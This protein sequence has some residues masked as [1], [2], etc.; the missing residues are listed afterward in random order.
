MKDSYVPGI[1]TTIVV[2]VIKDFFFLAAT[3]SLDGGATVGI[4]IGVLALVAL[5]MTG[6][7][8]TVIL[9]W[10]FKCRSGYSDFTRTKHEGIDNPNYGEIDYGTQQTSYRSIPEEYEGPQSK[11]TSPSYINVPYQNMLCSG[12][13]SGIYSY[14]V[15]KHPSAKSY[16]ST[17]LQSSSGS[18]AMPN[19]VAAN[20]DDE[21]TKQFATADYAILVDNNHNCS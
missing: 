2:L 17:F 3:T 15:V 5:A 10:H 13:T 21:Q 12:S 9:I 20:T 6:F 4:V 11:Q 1:A 14:V 16:D 7:V 18:L 8:L 19:V